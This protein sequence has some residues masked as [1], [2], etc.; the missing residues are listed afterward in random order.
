MKRFFIVALLT[1]LCSIQG[2]SQ[3]EAGLNWKDKNCG[4]CIWMAR[5]LGLPEGDFDKFRKIVHK[6]G[7]N[8]EKAALRSFEDWDKYAKQVYDNRMC[9]DRKIQRLVTAQQFELY[10]KYVRENPRRVHDYREWYNDPYFRGTRPTH[11][12]AGYEE[13]YWNHVWVSKD[14]KDNRNKNGLPPQVLPGSFKTS[15]K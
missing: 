1:L 4:T 2:Y 5:A 10:Q 15:K 6:H 3:F 8:I 7:Q 12:V 9:R 13:L 14:L 11:I